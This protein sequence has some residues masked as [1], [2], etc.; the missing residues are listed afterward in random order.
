MSNQAESI[1][2]KGNST[3]NSPSVEVVEIEIGNLSETQKLTLISVL[4]SFIVQLIF[5]FNLG[6][7]TDIFK[8]FIPSTYQI[9]TNYVRDFLNTFVIYLLVLF[10]VIE[11]YITYQVLLNDN[12]NI[13]LGAQ[14]IDNTV[15]VA[16]SF[17]AL[18]F[19]TIVTINPTPSIINE[20]FPNLVE[21]FLFLMMFTIMIVIELIP[22]YV[23]NMLTKRENKPVQSVPQTITN[24]S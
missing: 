9:L 3:P 20:T 5:L 13:Y 12:N 1:E 17:F 2:N 24:Q 10:L 11:I 21:L 8:N 19:I 15:I 22:F 16:L 7:V 6:F 4:G 14:I 23:S 18:F